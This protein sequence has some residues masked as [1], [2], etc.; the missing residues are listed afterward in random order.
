MKKI[1]QLI[2]YLNNFP[3][4]LWNF[5]TCIKIN[6][7]KLKELEDFL[8][9]TFP[10][11][12]KYFLLNYNGI[13]I[14]YEYIYGITGR[15][16]DDLLENYLSEHDKKIANPMPD[17]LIPFCPNGMGDHYCFNKKDNKIY[18]WQ[19]DCY[20]LNWN[21]DFD[22]ETFTNRLEENLKNALDNL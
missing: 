11:D 4:D 10:K 8:K 20:D 13:Q 14:P 22:N 18:F 12:F 9:Y 1:E 21:P 3:S 16:Y 2:K 19:H 5:N 17:F 7:S 15:K 6:E